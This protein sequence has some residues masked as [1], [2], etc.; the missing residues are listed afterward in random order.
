MRNSLRLKLDVLPLWQN[1]IPLRLNNMT[2][3]NQ[4]HYEK[5]WSVQHC[6]KSI[7][8]QNPGWQI[9]NN[10]LVLTTLYRNFSATFQWNI[11]LANQTSYPTQRGPVQIVATAVSLAVRTFSKNSQWVA[12]TRFQR[13]IYAVMYQSTQTCNGC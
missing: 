3:L 9:F 6:L 5:K 4:N 7:L 8:G 1:H 2:W 12:L 10:M 11:F 13:V